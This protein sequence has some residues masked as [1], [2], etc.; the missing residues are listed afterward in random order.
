MV[1]EHVLLPSSCLT[2]IGQ[3]SNFLEFHQQVPVCD[4]LLKHSKQINKVFSAMV[5]TVLIIYSNVRC[6][7]GGTYYIFI[8]GTLYLFFSNEQE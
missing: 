5:I 8:A 7:F 1:S 4:S 3:G 2:S 6:S